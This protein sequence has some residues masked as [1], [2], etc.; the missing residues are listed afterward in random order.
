MRNW[1]KLALPA[2]ILLGPFLTL[3]SCQ[4]TSVADSSVI[5]EVAEE[6]NE[7]ACAGLKPETR[8]SAEFNALSEDAQELLLLWDALWAGVCE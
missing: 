4:T 1:K 3:M 6:T 7:T 8:T 5:E 2:L